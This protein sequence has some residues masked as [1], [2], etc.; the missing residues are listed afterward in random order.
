MDQARPNSISA[1]TVAIIATASIVGTAI[2][3]ALSTC[4]LLRYRRKRKA[5]R[6]EEALINNE[7]GYNKPVAVRGSTSP[8]FPRFGRDSGSPM[9]NFKLPSLSPLIKAKKAQRE[10]KKIGLAA[11]DYGDQS[12][13]SSQSPSSETD[14]KPT[15]ADG[16][17]SSTTFR[18]Q[19]DNGVSNAT[20]VRLIRVGSEKGKGNAFTA[21]QKTGIEPMP[22]PPIRTAFDGPPKQASLFVPGPAPAGPAIQSSSRANPIVLSQPPKVKETSSEQQRQSAR[23]PEVESPDWRP[24]V[25]STIASRNRFRFRDSSDIESEEPT[26]TNLDPDANTAN[27][28]VPRASNLFPRVNKDDGSSTFPGRPKNAGATFATFPRLREGPRRESMIN[29]GRPMLRPRIRGNETATMQGR[30]STVT[31]TSRPENSTQEQRAVEDDSRDI[32]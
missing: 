20:T 26:P 17:Q 19:K 3:T 12:E 13:G 31:T 6:Q 28:R 11:S 24:S 30:Q 2:L 8:R 29:R 10:Q 15:N 32:F 4:F 7:K 9:D 16:A 1:S 22:P 18:L 25:R 27:P 14:K 21:N 5:S 23:N